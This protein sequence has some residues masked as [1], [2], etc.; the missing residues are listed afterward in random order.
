[1]SKA[2]YHRMERFLDAQDDVF[3]GFFGR[4]GGISREIYSS[5]N[6]GAGSDDD[7]AHIVQNKA[8]VAAEAGVGADNLLTLYQTHSDQ[9]LV[10]D[11][12]WDGERQQADAMV[13]KTRGVALGILTA[14]CAPVLFYGQARDGVPVIG[15]A[16]AGW[17]GALGGVLGSTVEAMGSLGVE[18]AD[19]RACIGPCITKA[20][21]E[22]REEF[23]A[24]FMAEDDHNER[25]FGSARNEGH[26]MFD[27]AGY[28][29]FKLWKVGV[30]HVSIQGTDTYANEAQFFSYRRAT[31][32]REN[33]YGRQ[34]SVICLNLKA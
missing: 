18:A 11:G 1:M 19:I 24:P 8:R 10:V 27:L 23:A 4:E 34:I 21:Y 25:F 22:V 12:L 33:D 17:S 5:L 32:R 31:H 30:L 15:A 28:C 7:P 9:C 26:L 2:I 20:S 29:A 16:H 13:T 14:D 3:H 6:C